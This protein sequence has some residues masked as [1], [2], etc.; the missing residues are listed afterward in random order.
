MKYRRSENYKNLAYEAYIQEEPIKAIEFFNKALEFKNTK[1]EYKN[2]YLNLAQ[3]YDELGDNNKSLSA[4]KYI[5]ENTDL[6][7][8]GNY[9]MAKK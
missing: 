1:E 5:A 8:T 9:G 7:A 3:I 2:I 4:Y 6:K